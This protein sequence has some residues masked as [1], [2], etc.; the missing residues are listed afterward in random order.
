MIGEFIP[1]TRAKLEKTPED[2][3]VHPTGTPKHFNKLKK[4][5][6]ASDCSGEPEPYSS[7]N[8]KKQDQD[9]LG[10]GNADP[11][12]KKPFLEPSFTDGV[13][14]QALPSIPSFPVLYP[15]LLPAISS[16][17]LEPSEAVPPPPENRYPRNR[18]P[19]SGPRMR[20]G[21]CRCTCLGS[22][23]GQPCDRRHVPLKLLSLI[24]I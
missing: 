7:D 4:G 21:N 6:L 9:T 11:M 13:E 17:E 19:P 23:S 3:R 12:D 20:L 16:G 22:Q 14:I 8:G 2:Q 15:V 1:P 5:N 18:P 10:R 24:H